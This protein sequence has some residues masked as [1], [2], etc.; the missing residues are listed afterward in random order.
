MSPSH[1]YSFVFQCLDLC[2]H[3][4]STRQ[5]Y[6]IYPNYPPPKFPV[7]IHLNRNLNAL[8]GDLIR[9]WYGKRMSETSSAHNER[10]KLLFRRVIVFWMES[11][12]CID[13]LTAN[14]RLKGV[15]LNHPWMRN[16][17]YID[18]NKTVA[19]QKYANQLHKPKQ[20]TYVILIG[21]CKYYRNWYQTQQFRT[22]FAS[23]RVKTAIAV[24]CDADT[25]TPRVPFCEYQ[26]FESCN[27]LTVTSISPSF[28]GN[29]S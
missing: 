12:G 25:G 14:I 13:V 26:S 8:Q 7:H 4:R 21:C 3:I 28:T 15:N 16:H 29:T 6:I 22:L 1:S 2:V 20:W 17:P 9:L 18:S 24:S 23:C 27:H 5:L 10:S 19:L 11:L